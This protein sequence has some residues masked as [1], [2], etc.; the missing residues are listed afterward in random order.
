VSLSLTNKGKTEI[1]RIPITKANLGF[2][3]LILYSFRNF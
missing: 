3:L 2:A 1:H